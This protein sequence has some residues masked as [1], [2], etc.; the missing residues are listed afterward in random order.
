MSIEQI[1]TLSD[2]TAQIRQMSTKEIFHRKRSGSKVEEKLL[3][4]ISC[5]LV[6]ISWSNAWSRFEHDT[7][8]S[9][10]ENREIM[11]EEAFNV[12]T[13]VSNWRS[14]WLNI[15]PRPLKLNK[16]GKKKDCRWL[17]NFSIAPLFFQLLNATISRVKDSQVVIVKQSSRVDTIIISSKHLSGSSGEFRKLATSTSFVRSSFEPKTS[18]RQ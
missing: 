1:W 2:R 5:L 15:P 3:K 13:L 11:K 14:D 10:N 6:S 18:F 17:L 7:R 9:A 8:H 12:R 16:M 4:I